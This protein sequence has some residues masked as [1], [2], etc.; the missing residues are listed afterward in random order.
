MSSMLPFRQPEAK[1][2]LTRAGARGSIA[3][4][5]YAVTVAVPTL[6]VVLFGSMSTPLLPDLSNLVFD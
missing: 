1:P 2:H 4:W 6:L 3:H 5:S